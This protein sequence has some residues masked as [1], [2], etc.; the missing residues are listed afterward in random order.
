M[1]IELA[2]GA[3]SGEVIEELIA[4]GA[5]V[6]F[7]DRLAFFRHKRI[8]SPALGRMEWKSRCDTGADEAR[9]GTRVL[10]T[11]PTRPLRR[12]GRITPGVKRL[13]NYCDRSTTKRNQLSPAQDFSAGGLHRAEAL[14]FGRPRRQVITKAAAPVSFST[15]LPGR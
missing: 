5:S 13:Q 11:E 9:C 7:E 14:P 1:L 6:A 4:H 3:A 8:Y 15:D 12:S 2:S 10:E